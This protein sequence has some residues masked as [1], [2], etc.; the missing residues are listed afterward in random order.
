MLV[1]HHY[2]LGAILFWLTVVVMCA[3]A[4]P[5]AD[6]AA[7]QSERAYRVLSI[8]DGD[9][10]SV[11][12]EDLV[13]RIQLLGIDA[14]EDIPNPKLEQDRKRT[15]LN[16][17]VLI[18]M[19]QSATRHLNS[20]IAP[21]Q[22]VRLEGD[23]Q[24]RDRYGRIPAVVYDRQGRSLNEAMVEAGYAIVLDG[25]PLPAQ[26]RTR[27]IRHEEAAIANGRGLWGSYYDAVSVWSGRAGTR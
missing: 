22:T 23:L 9:T 11:G 12:L 20:I 21:G 10:L 25:D 1:N 24:K 19:G 6:S 4:L 2:Q 15:G 8:E 14:P 5:A 17:D 27:L 26:L 7:Q 13:Q 16:Q 18:A 3:L